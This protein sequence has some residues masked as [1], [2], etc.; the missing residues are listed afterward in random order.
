LVSFA[1]GCPSRLASLAVACSTLPL[2]S[3]TIT[4]VGSVRMWACRM[5]LRLQAESAGP[6]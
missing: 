1:I 5:R 2:W 6:L 4:A 3:S